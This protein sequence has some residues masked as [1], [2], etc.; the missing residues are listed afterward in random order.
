MAG[1]LEPPTPTRDAEARGRARALDPAA[2]AQAHLARLKACAADRARDGFEAQLEVRLGLD[3]DQVL[4]Q[5]DRDRADAIQAPKGVL[6]ALDSRASLEAH[7][8]DRHHLEA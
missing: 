8:D 4:L 7:G 5:I 1:D 6:D 3:L 2:R